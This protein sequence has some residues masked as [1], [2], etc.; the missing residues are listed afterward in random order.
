MR[1]RLLTASG[2]RGTAMLAALGLAG[3]FSVPPA[4]LVDALA[5]LL[6]AG[7][8]MWELLRRQPQG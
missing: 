1:E 8:S 2:A 7:I 6:L 5:K 4:D 3:N